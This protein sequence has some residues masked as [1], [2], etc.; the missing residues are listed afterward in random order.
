MPD[1]QD[2]VAHRSMLSTLSSLPKVEVAPAQ[3]RMML[4]RVYLLSS[5]FL[6][7]DELIIES[8]V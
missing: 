7:E 6:E 5:R 2:D 8:F 4:V 1:E 3:R